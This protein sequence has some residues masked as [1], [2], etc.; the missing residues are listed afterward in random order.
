MHTI[1]RILVVSRMT[2]YCANAVH[3]GVSLSRQLG[4]ELYVLHVTENPSKC[5]KRWNLSAPALNASNGYK[6]V[7]QKAKEEL[8]AIINAERSNG[9]HI[10]EMIK[11]GDPAEIIMQ[12]ADE[13][14]IDLIIMTAHEEG[15]LEEVIFGYS[16]EQII[17][18]MPCSIL[19]VKTEP[20]VL[21]VEY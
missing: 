6:I 19:L 4:A 16:N 12:V 13:K 18:K 15:H 5:G 1:K 3:C 17:R 7:F 21:G 8:S 14:D 10:I 2:R 20:A 9:V 11:A